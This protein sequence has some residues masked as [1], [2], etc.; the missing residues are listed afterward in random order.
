[1]LGKY[2]IAPVGFTLNVTFYEIICSHGAGSVHIAD[3]VIGEAR[4]V[5]K[6]GHCIWG[7]DADG[8]IWSTGGNVPIT[9]G[10][11]IGIYIRS[12][13]GEIHSPATF[14]LEV[15]RDI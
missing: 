10:N 12:N 9:A 2:N 11:A 7:V 8:I 14:T 15:Q 1:M 13:T 3:N 5:R 6:C 4:I